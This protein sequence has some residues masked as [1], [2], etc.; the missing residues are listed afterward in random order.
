MQRKPSKKAR[1]I[2]ARLASVQAIYQI[3]MLPSMT[4]RDAIEDYKESRM[5]KPVEGDDYVP[6]DLE[7]MTKI[8][9]GVVENRDNL[10]DMVLGALE[11]KKPEPLIQAILF[12]GMYELMAH[13]DVDVPVIINDY[14]NVAHG[15]YEQ[16][17]ANLVNAV[18]DRQAKN[19]RV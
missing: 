5:N 17:E 7:L 14:V 2:A 13:T 16:S 8:V 10:R 3:A 6:A 11:G 1:L 4:A 18:L 15:F 12:C 9:T 19:I